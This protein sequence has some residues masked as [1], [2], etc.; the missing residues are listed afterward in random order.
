MRAKVMQTEV[1]I[2]GNNVSAA[3][4]AC[5]V[6]LTND[7]RDLVILSQLL[8]K[9][10]N[11]LGEAL[12]VLGRLLQ[13]SQVCRSGISASQR[14]ELDGRLIVSMGSGCLKVRLDSP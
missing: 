14:V 11:V 9:G 2:G 4:F 10:V 7:G 1:G 8:A 3:F 6:R 13:G 12:E 5:N